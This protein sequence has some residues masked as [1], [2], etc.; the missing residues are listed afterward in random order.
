[1]N[2]SR[3]LQVA[4]LSVALS[5][6]GSDPG[7]QAKPATA[8]SQVQAK[9]A[10]TAATDPTSKM[11]RAVGN[12]KPGSAVDIKYEFL[13]RPEVGK[14]IEVEIVL[15]PSAGVDAMDATFSG[16]EGVTLAGTLNASFTEVK[17]GEPYQHR[18]SILP[19]RNGVFYITVTVNT[20]IGGAT[21]ARTFSIPFVVGDATG[22]QK[23]KVAPAKDAS[24]QPIQPMK[25]EE[26]KG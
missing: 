12:G 9:R 16:M 26:G 3:V 1:M 18:I 4:A 6:C 5:A 21:L 22:Q 19:D 23:P 15:I 7:S 20:Q 10:A 13:A 17:S 24:G 11:A 8:P 25:A 14:P 2:A